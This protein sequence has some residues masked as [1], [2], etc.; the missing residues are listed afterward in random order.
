MIPPPRRSAVA[1][2]IR[3]SGHPYLIADLFLNRGLL[4]EDDPFNFLT[5]FQ[6]PTLMVNGRSIFTFQLDT[7]QRPLFRLLGAPEKDKLVGKPRQNDW[8]VRVQPPQLELHRPGRKLTEQ[9]GRRRR[10][11][12]SK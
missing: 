11:E 9:S 8:W 4:R 2:W 12:S 7:S 1:R 6:V 5:C 10:P 3:L